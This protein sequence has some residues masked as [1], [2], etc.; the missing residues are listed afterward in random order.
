MSELKIG[1]NST[2]NNYNPVDKSEPVPVSAQSKNV[3]VDSL[4]Q[5]ETS[6]TSSISNKNLNTPQLPP[7]SKPV[8][9]FLDFLDIV[10]AAQLGFQQMIREAEDVRNNPQLQVPARSLTKESEE[11][12]D[13]MDALANAE[14]QVDMETDKIM[15]ELGDIFNQARAL[16]TAQNKLI[17]QIQEGNEEQQ[18]QLE[19]IVADY[20]HYIDGLIKLGAT[21]D[22]NGVYTIPDT[23]EAQ[24]EY[25]R[26][27][28]EYQTSVTEF[29]QYWA[30]R[31]EE[32]NQYNTATETY[33]SQA[34]AINQNLQTSLGPYVQ[35]VPQMPLA[36]LIPISSSANSPLTSPQNQADNQV[37]VG[38][39]PSYIDEILQ[40]N[41]AELSPLPTSTFNAQQIQ[42]NINDYLNEKYVAPLDLQL[43]A[44]IDNFSFKLYLSHQKATSLGDLDASAAYENLRKTLTSSEESLTTSFDMLAPEAEEGNRSTRAFIRKIL[45]AD[46]LEIYLNKVSL[47]SSD[48]GTSKLALLSL[49]HFNKSSSYALSSLVQHMGK[50]LVDLPQD[51]SS[52]TLLFTLMFSTDFIE[53]IKNGHFDQKVALQMS[54]IS[55]LSNL[56][57]ET[58]KTLSNILKINQLLILSRLVEVNVGIQGFTQSLTGKLSPAQ[59]KSVGTEVAQMNEQFTSKILSSSVSALKAL[60]LSDD[61]AQFVAQ[62]GTNALSKGLFLAPSV[63]IVSAASIDQALLIDSVA[64]ALMNSPAQSLSLNTCISIAETAIKSVLSDGVPRT[65]ESFKKA[66]QNELVES[67]TQQFSKTAA[68]RALLV[69]NQTINFAD[70]STSEGYFKL[71]IGNQFGSSAVSDYKNNLEAVLNDL[72][73]QLSANLT[74]L[75][76]NIQN[77]LFINAM[78]ITPSYHNFLSSFSNSTDILKHSIGS[79][80]NIKIN[81]NLL[82]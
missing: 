31:I 77:E 20:N 42:K 67:G 24:A 37:R 3:A 28:A 22:G 13:T 81:T 52:S 70:Y 12:I 82:G 50:A 19:K 33:N 61:K 47:S 11:I 78:Q 35:N 54:G 38:S 63:S 49:D 40:Q 69:P 53:Q 34:T 56:L 55:E 16:N 15:N 46:I 29:N 73:A 27:T 76:E 72:T 7:P 18:E 9:S 5:T 60:G 80:E 23:P 39:L 36:P 79:I 25:L 57:P 45:A 4:S 32:I 58:K 43:D 6:S 75:P 62:F 48:L 64:V 26:L 44:Q 59:A 65:P 1:A 30:G 21:T 2:S 71:L 17:N 14:K 66:L 41:P 74:A 10:A 51:S 8:I 68:M